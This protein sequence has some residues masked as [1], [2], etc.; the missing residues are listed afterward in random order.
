MLLN[1]LLQIAR[2]NGICSTVFFS[3]HS[4]CHAQ[5]CPG[6]TANLEKSAIFLH[7][8]FDLTEHLV[9]SD[10]ESMVVK[11]I[12]VHLLGTVWHLP[13]GEQRQYP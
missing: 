4:K 2:V 5:K 10:L 13:H 1:V 7:Y 12:A 9:G 8:T 3:H 11:T 6:G